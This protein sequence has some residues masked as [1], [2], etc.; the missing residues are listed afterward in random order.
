VDIPMVETSSEL[1][2]REDRTIEDPTKEDPTRV[3][4]NPCL[5]FRVEIPRVDIDPFTLR[6]DV[7]II[8]DT[9]MD[10]PFITLN[11]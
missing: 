6:S 7:T 5:R 8:D 9:V 3:E 10:D 11:S 1:T 2:T 4:K